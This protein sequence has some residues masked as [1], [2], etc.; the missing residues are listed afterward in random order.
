MKYTPEVLISIKRSV[1][2]KQKHLKD[3]AVSNTVDEKSFTH[4]ILPILLPQPSD[5]QL[6]FVSQI[7]IC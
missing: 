7:Q 6:P 2:R 1:N 4:Y 5:G 3:D